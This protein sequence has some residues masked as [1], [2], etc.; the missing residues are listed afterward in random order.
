MDGEN[1]PGKFRATGKP[2]GSNHGH[3]FHRYFS[4]LRDFHGLFP[5]GSKRTVLRGFTDLPDQRIK[6]TEPVQGLF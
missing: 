3:R 6:E 4:K 5:T 2:V 1:Y